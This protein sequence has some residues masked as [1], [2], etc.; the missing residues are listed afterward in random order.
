VAAPL[1]AVLLL[2][3]S[4]T[5]V[6]LV[7]RSG[8]SAT[9]RLLGTH[10]VAVVVTPGEAAAVKDREQARS[11]LWGGLGVILL[12][13]FI[14]VMLFTFLLFNGIMHLHS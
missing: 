7:L 11:A 5:N 6:V 4:V 9:D 13:A 8:V 14:T 1:L 12:L 3:W 2:G 10:I